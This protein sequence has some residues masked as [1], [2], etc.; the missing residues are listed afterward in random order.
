MSGRNRN[1]EGTVS[2]PRKDGR[3]VGAFYAP[4]NAGTTKRVYVYGRSYDEAREKLIAEQAKVMAGIPVPDKSWKLGPYL[5]YWLENVV[6]PTRRPATIALYEMQ[7][8]LYLKPGLGKHPLRRLSVPIVQKFLNDKIKELKPGQSVRNVHVMR[9]ILSA[10][11]SRAMREELV[12]RNVARLV[13]LPAWEAAEVIPWSAAEALAFLD[14]AADDPLHPAFVLLLLYG[15]RRGEVLGLAWVDIDDD[16]IR[17]RQQ[18]QRVAGQLRLGLVKTTAG[19][20]DLPVLSLAA[21][22]LGVRRAVQVT[23]RERLGAAWSDT[24]LVF[25]SRSGLPIE[26]RNVDRTFARICKDNGLRRI[27]LHDLRHTTATLLKALGVPPKDA[28]VILGHAHITT[29]NQIYTHVD[30]PAKREALSKLNRLL[31]GDDK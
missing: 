11:L 13:E 8:R 1:G 2:G 3:Y 9:Q 22:A 6:K 25:T 24:G 18:V 12:S 31:G 5:D 21:K 15:L 27:R 16:T 30:E 28:Q 19:K 14:A 4:T 29:T 17:V 20:R 7:I 10:A 26:P 23:D